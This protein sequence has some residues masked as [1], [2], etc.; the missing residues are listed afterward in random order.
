MNNFYRIGILVGLFVLTVVS[1]SAAS[2]CP[3]QPTNPDGTT[4]TSPTPDQV[5]T[6]PFT[7]QGMYYGSFEGVV[8]IQLLDASGAEIVRVNAK[9]ECCVLSPYQQQISFTV[10]APTP[11]CLVVSRENGK[12]DTLTPV[13]Q[14]PIIVPAFGRMW[15]DSPSLPRP[16]VP[17]L[18]VILGLRGG[19]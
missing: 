9:N 1:T 19:G 5:V 11:A 10:S 7:V 13:V 17:G 14:I 16:R 8:P 6:S 2:A 15:R 3:A 18:S 12:D 4:I